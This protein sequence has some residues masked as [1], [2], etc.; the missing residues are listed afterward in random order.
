M[1]SRNS[2][3]FRFTWV[4]HPLFLVAFVLL[5]LKFSDLFFF[6]RSLFFPFSFFFFLPLYC[7]FFFD[8]RLLM[9]PLISFCHCIVCSSLIYGFWWPLW[10]LFA[11]VLSV[12]FR[13]TASDYPFGI[14]KLFLMLYPIVLF[15]LQIHIYHVY[16]SWTRIRMLK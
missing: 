13:F 3:P 12:L 5:D 11:I 14:F 1:W 8:L 9:T 4:H 7:L 6:Y 16:F 2:L 15:L 10:Y